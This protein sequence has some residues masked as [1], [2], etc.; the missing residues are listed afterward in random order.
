MALTNTEL[1][2]WLQKQIGQTLDIRKGELTDSRNEISDMHQIMLHLD[3]VLVRRT[4]HPDD[5]VADEELVLKGHGTT[6]T[7]EGNV[8]LPQDAYEIPLLG[9]I[10]IQK[11]QDGL[12]V[13]TDGRLYNRPGKS[14]KKEKTP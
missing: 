7:E 6:Y 9:D 1:S 8:P 10:T 3:D 14:N 13:H 2:E 5:Y 11:E 12:K 4:N